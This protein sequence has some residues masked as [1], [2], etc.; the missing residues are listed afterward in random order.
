MISARRAR[1]GDLDKG[2]SQ[3]FEAGGKVLV[4]SR[5]FQSRSGPVNRAWQCAGVPASRREA[6]SE[7]AVVRPQA[8]ALREVKALLWESGNDHRTA[9]LEHAKRPQDLGST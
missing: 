4:L 8:S 6:P 3:R 1:E 5:T 9:H 7:T 2:D